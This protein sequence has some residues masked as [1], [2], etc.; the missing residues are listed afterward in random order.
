ML[1]TCLTESHLE[2][3]D[4]FSVLARARQLLP[5]ARS[6]LDHR[7]LRNVDLMTEAVRACGTNLSWE[8]FNADDESQVAQLLGVFEGSFYVIGES[9][10][11]GGLRAIQASPGELANVRLEVDISFDVVMVGSHDSTI[12]LIHH[13]SVCAVVDCPSPGV[14]LEEPRHLEKLML[15]QANRRREEA[16]GR[17]PLRMRPALLTILEQGRSIGAMKY[18]HSE[19]GW[20]LQNAKK[21][22]DAIAIRWPSDLANAT[23]HRFATS[24]VNG[25]DGEHA[26]R[27]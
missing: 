16:L 4:Y 2:A 5:A 18:L 14:S 24:G 26:W 17:V 1:H 7:A 25:D 3:V 8:R 10:P 15:E 12:Q 6:Q 22:V 19:L 27:M 13:E 23:E 9:A 21:T 11:D 20:S